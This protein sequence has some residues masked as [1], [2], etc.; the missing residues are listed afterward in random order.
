MLRRSCYKMNKN[1]ICGIYKITNIIDGKCYVG[2]SVDIKNRWSRH[3]SNLRKGKH[4]N[5][6]MQSAWHKYKEENFKFE[7][8]EE[9]N[10]SYINEKEIHYIHL[11]NSTNRDFGYNLDLGGNSD[12]PSEETKIKC[13][14]S[15]KSKPIYQVDFEGNIV[16]YWEFGARH[17]SSVLEIAQSNIQK[18]LKNDIKTAGGFI[19]VYPDKL[20]SINIYERT[21]AKKQGIPIAKLDLYNGFICSYESISKTRN[22][23]FDMRAVIRCCKNKAIQHKGFKF[24]YYEDYLKQSDRY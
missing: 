22:D 23:G 3:K 17:A 12:F 1:K 4:Q 15:Q 14:K 7:I 8:L 10:K 5:Q 18:C 19:W 9:C 16:N 13:R 6:H 21:H 24:M 11:Y 2:Q 20:D